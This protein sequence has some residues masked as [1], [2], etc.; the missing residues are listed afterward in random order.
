ML[1]DGCGGNYKKNH[2]I[3]DCSNCLIPHAKGSYD[4][5]M[6]K[7]KEVIKNGSDF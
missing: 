1:K 2:G 6:S 5:I 4:I 7:I 3:K